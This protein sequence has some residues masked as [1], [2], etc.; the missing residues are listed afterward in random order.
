[1][2]LESWELIVLQITLGSLISGIILFLFSVIVSSMNLDHSGPDAP[3]SDIHFDGFGSDTDFGSNVELDHHLNLEHLEGSAPLMLLM[4]TFFLMFGSIG[5]PIYQ[6][7]LFTPLLR[8]LISIIGPL[9]FVKLVSLVWRRFLA[10]ESA[11]EIPHVK[12]D[13]QVTTLTKVDENGGLVLADTSDIDR[14]QEKLHLAGDIKMQA[15]TRNNLVIGRGETA[16]VIE[17]QPNNT[18]IIDT[19]PKATKKN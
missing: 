7:E 4:S 12:V 5:Y 2:A 3:D 17:I 8:L 14:T 6:Y 13:N 11:Y 19:W 18:L 10:S 15:K 9:I 16:Y 1:M